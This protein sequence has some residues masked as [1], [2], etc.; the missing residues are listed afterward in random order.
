MSSG[1]RA[2]GPLVLLVTGS[3][4]I[5]AC[6]CLPKGMADLDVG[7][8]QRGIASWYGEDFHGWATASGEVYNMEALTAAHRTLPLGT[9][10][11]VTNALNGKQVR[12]RINDR[13]PYVNGRVLDL[14]YAAA[15]TLGMV[16]NGISAVYLEVIGGHREQFLITEGRALLAPIPVKS[17]HESL[18]RG[19]TKSAQTRLMPIDARSARAFRMP[20]GDFMREKRTRRVADF[21]AAEQRV[22]TAA[23]RSL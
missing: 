11:R 2:I 8:K 15:R 17:S 1:K 21:M 18:N 23:A 20:P 6:S 10:I 7:A 16:Q 9:V 22:Y 5:S 3:L 19:A 4:V 14:S 13:G 12:V